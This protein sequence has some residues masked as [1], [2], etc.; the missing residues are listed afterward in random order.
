MGWQNQ[1]LIR[2]IYIAYHNKNNATFSM[3]KKNSDQDTDFLN[4]SVFTCFYIIQDAEKNAVLSKEKVTLIMMILFG[5][6]A[7]WRKSLLHY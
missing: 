6:K 2:K 5:I 4:Q 1:N 3:E 7:H